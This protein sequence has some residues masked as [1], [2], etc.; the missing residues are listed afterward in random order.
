MAKSPILVDYVIE[1]LR[2]ATPKSGGGTNHFKERQKSI[3]TFFLCMREMTERKRH[4][5]MLCENIDENALAPILYYC[6]TTASQDQVDWLFMILTEMADDNTSREADIMGELHLLRGLAGN[7]SNDRPTLK[8]KVHQFIDAQQADAEL[9]GTVDDPE[10]EGSG[11]KQSTGS[12][13]A[14]TSPAQNPIRPHEPPVSVEMVSIREQPKEGSFSDDIV[15][16]AVRD[17]D[18]FK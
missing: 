10:Y 13:L 11:E 3:H 1:S 8:H 4:Q 16:D 7:D 15:S 2:T 18:I 5:N 17:M 12:T 6:L 9:I 14:E